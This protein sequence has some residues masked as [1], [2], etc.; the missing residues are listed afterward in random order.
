MRWRWLYHLA[1]KYI[2]YCNREWSKD[3]HRYIDIK[4]LKYI[5]YNS[6]TN[7]ISFMALMQSGLVLVVMIFWTML[8]RDLVN[9]KRLNLKEKGRILVCIV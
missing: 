7:I 5:T 8:Y 4:N 3:Q 2:G 9:M 6:G 1:V